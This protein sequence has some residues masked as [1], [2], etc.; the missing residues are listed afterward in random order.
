MAGNKIQS[1]ECE[2]THIFR[3]FSAGYT[4]PAGAMTTVKQ[5]MKLAEL[6][7]GAKFAVET[8]KHIVISSFVYAKNTEISPLFLLGKFWGNGL[9][10]HNF[11]KGKWKFPF[12]LNFP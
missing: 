8:S 6:K 10:P 5:T 12:P 9:I 7:A 4:K 3:P 1:V 11:P 2:E